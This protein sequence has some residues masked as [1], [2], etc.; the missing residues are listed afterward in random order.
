MIKK[1]QKIINILNMLSDGIII[2]LS[3]FVS[4][5]IRFVVMK[6]T[7]SLIL[8]RYP[9]TLVAVLYSLSMVFFYYAMKMYGS[10]RFK[11]VGA[12]N[13]T[14]VTINGIGVMSLMAVMYLLRLADFSRSVL[15]IYWAVSTVAIIL[16]RF[17]VR[18]ILHH[19]R[20]LGYNQ[21]HVIIVG[22]GHHAFQYIEDLKR[23][24]QL[25]ITVDGY[26]SKY[27]KEGLGKCLG[28]YEELET[29]LRENDI[30]ELIVALEPHEIHFMKYVISCADKEGVRLSL[31]PFFNDFFPTHVRME[32][33][34]KSKLIDMRATPLDNLMAGA[35]K[36]VIDICGSV[37]GIIVLSPVML[38]TAIGVK[39][40]SPGP[41]L[42]KQDRIGL[43]KKPFKML[44]FRSMRVN[45][46][47]QTGWSTDTDPR[48]TKF[49]SIIRKFSIDE[50]P[51]LFN[52][53]K[54]DMS[55]VG[56]RP[57]VPHYVRQFKE[58]VPLYLLR[59]QIR[60][61]M[62]GWAQVNGL[63]GDTSIE[64]RVKYDIWYIENWSLWLDIKILFKTVFGGMIN[65][66][67]IN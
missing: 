59:Q 67:K 4:L 46:T 37:F 42:F 2:F 14:I 21:K 33:V 17:I 44:K 65:S 22:N 62:T 26:V 9:Y 5:F 29:I 40:S 18:K 8:W 20:R 19:Y 13:L 31:I 50:L 25:G 64:E 3:Y 34:G 49:G 52:V 6:G 60:P 24:P 45:T 7:I 55:L 47:E 57:E 43:N 66:E 54:G 15:M 23:N 32:R 12:E 38:I 36:R 39:L 63:R 1:N 56:P 58:D 48:K 51:Q 41:I 53:L 10:Y 27:Q 35:V 30:D 16:K 61:G 28:S 11:A